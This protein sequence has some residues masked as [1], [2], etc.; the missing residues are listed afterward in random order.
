MVQFYMDG[1]AFGAPVAL[2]ASGQASIQ[3]STLSL[4]FH[5]V[6]AQYLG[7]PT[8]ASSTGTATQLVQ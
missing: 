5:V 4:G 7:N 8:Y 1:V 3:N 2:N 6:T